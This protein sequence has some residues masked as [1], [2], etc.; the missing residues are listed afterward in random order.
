M[1]AETPA[2]DASPH[3]PPART[4]RVLFVSPYVPSPIRVRPYQLLRQLARRGHTVTLVCPATAGD[5]SALASLRLAGA[6]VVAVPYGRADTLAAYLKALP[7]PLPLQAAH[8]LTPAFVQA[9]RGALGRAGFDVVHVE[10]LRGAEVARVAAR[11]LRRAPPLILD[12]VDSISLLFE[13]AVRH[14][15]APAARAMAL[16]DLAP[17]RRYEASYGRGFARVVCTS[18]EDRWALETLREHFGEPPGAPVAVVPNGVDQDFFRPTGAA[19]DAATIVFSGKMSYHANEAAARFLL[20]AIM[21]LVWRARPQARVGS[22]GAAPGPRPLAYARDPRV[23]VTGYVPDLRPYL[24][25]ATVAVAPLRYGVGVQNKVLEAM[26]MGTPLVAAR[27]ATVALGARP[28]DELLVADTAQ[29]FADQICALLADP[30]RRAW[31]GRAARSFVGP[32]H[33]WAGSAAALE[34]CYAATLS[35]G[36]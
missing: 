25:R 4:L 12:A 17:T 20:D 32:R 22:A 9:V 15:R 24:A 19:R 2:R 23:Q 6:E 26:A 11:G 14:G 3:G 16:L 31:Q 7:G 8:C 36:H 35:G 29:T 5:T 27:Q 13:R 21:P 10:H 33:S 18:P 28:G 30:A 34:V 1:I